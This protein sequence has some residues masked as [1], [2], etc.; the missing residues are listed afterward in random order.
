MGQSDQ[1]LLIGQTDQIGLFLKGHETNVLT[2]AVHILGYFLTSIYLKF[3]VPTF[4][5]NLAILYSNIWSH[6]VITRQWTSKYYGGETSGGH[7][8][9]KWANPASFCLFSFFQTQILQKKL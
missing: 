6:C 2:N 7:F 3:V 8:F 4:N 9:K 5:K 1:I